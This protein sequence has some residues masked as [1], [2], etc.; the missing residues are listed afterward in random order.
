MPQLVRIIIVAAAIL[1]G[2]L[3][4]SAQT[5]EPITMP[6]QDVILSFVMPGRI[7][8]IPVKQGDR[9]KTGDLLIKLD[10]AAE[11][12]SAEQLKRQAEDTIKI[13]YAEAQFDLKKVMLEKMEA[14]QQKSVATEI[15]VAQ[16][17][18]EAKSADLSLELARF[19][20]TQA[21]LKYKEVIATLKRMSLLSPFDGLVER[22]YEQPGVSADRDVKIMRVVKIDPLYIDAPV[23]R[24][25]SSRLRLEQ[26]VKVGFHD[27]SAQQTGKII[28]IASVADAG[29]DTVTVRVEL[30]NPSLRRA[31]ERVSIDFGPEG[32]A[33]TATAPVD[34]LGS[35]NPKEE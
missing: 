16:A 28:F 18:L 30:P 25:Q 3:G 22:I 5:I 1:L 11:Q 27:D 35:R 34:T 17:R 20:K 24:Q 15:E 6:S 2:E 33:T 4:A 29:S 7:D 9:V 26:A 19:E 12:A 14:A 13:R 8:S 21:E 31:G 23:S 10:D 32:V